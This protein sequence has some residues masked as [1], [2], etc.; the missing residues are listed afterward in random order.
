MSSQNLFSHAGTPNTPSPLL[1]SYPNG[2]LPLAAPSTPRPQV[3]YPGIVQ[4]AGHN[5][6]RQVAGSRSPERLLP[7]KDVH[8]PRH[9]WP[10]DPQDRKSLMMSLH[11]THV[12]SPTRIVRTHEGDN[13]EPQRYYQAV[14]SLPIPPVEISSVNRLHKFE[15]TV[16]DE[17]YALIS[18]TEIAKK[19]GRFS[20]AEHFNG[21]LRW[22]LRACELKRTVD[23]VPAEHEW[24]V[25]ETSWPPHISITLNDQHIEL[26]RYTHNGRDLP[27]ELT[28]LVRCG[29]NLLQIG[30]G[31]QK[32]NSASMYA[33]AVELVETRSHSDILD[34][35]WK[36]G[37]I[38][39]E[40]TLETIISR[41]TRTEDDD[42]VSLVIKDLS[43][44]L[45]DPFSSVIFK[46]PARGVA[47]THMECFDLENWLNTRPAKGPQ[48]CHLHAPIPCKCKTTFEPSS[49]DKWKCPICSKDA[50]PYSLR[51]DGFLLKVRQQLERENKLH[52]KSMLVAPDGTWNAVVEEDDG[53]GDSDDDE[54]R[55]KLG[56]MKSNSVAPT[57]ARNQNIEVIELLDD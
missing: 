23:P 18:K 52:A 10:Y 8:I 48:K 55:L 57:T 13:G 43:I 14:K 29:Q 19:V 35:I 3:V 56:S 25:L 11:Q 27:A 15:F 31:E 33:A 2:H 30:V 37:H 26:R 1:P 5:I 40:I 32:K 36:H 41:S 22:R 16:T 46:I 6:P 20:V 7:P 49:P 44:D 54:P 51:I 12:R 53:D 24:A 9:D 39:E 38:P 50:R 4:S 17:Q 21:S 42:G 45:A 34:Y 47:C 28:T